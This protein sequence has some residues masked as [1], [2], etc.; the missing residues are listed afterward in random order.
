MHRDR[1]R[2]HLPELGRWRLGPF[3]CALAALVGLGVAIT[4]VM[5]IVNP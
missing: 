4:I 2:R 5:A 1:N 3:E